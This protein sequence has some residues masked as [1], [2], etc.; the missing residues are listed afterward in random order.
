MS[1]TRDNSYQ[2][3]VLSGRALTKREL[4]LK[5]ITENNGI[6][7]RQISNGT[8]LYLSSVCARVNELLQEGKIKE[9]G[10]VVCHDT[11]KEVSTLF[12]I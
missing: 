11:G 10:T 7:R 9:E 5:F 2:E 8:G 6:S 1:F 3:E 12:V 4:V